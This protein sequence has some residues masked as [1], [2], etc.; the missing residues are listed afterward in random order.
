MK[1]RNS[2][3]KSICVLA[4]MCACLACSDNTATSQSYKFEGNEMTHVSK[5][6]EGEYIFHVLPGQI[7]R[8][9]EDGA[10]KKTVLTGA[11]GRVIADKS[12]FYF[13]REGENQSLR[14]ENCFGYADIEGNIIFEEEIERLFAEESDRELYLEVVNVFLENDTIYFVINTKYFTQRIYYFDQEHGRLQHFF[15]MTERREI[16]PDSIFFITEIKNGH[17]YY[18]KYSIDRKRHGVWKTTLDDPD[19]H[20]EELIEENEVLQSICYIGNDFLLGH[21]IE[22]NLIKIEYGRQGHKQ[23]IKNEDFVHS[24][25]AVQCDGEWIL[26]MRENDEK[27]EVYLMNIDGTDIMKVTDEWRGN[28]NQAL[29][30]YVYNFVDAE[31]DDD[32]KRVLMRYHLAL[33]LDTGEISTIAEW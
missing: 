11:Y 19:N 23:L 9:K 8:T 21:D 13:T 12:G 27:Y 15:E 10:D 24:P 4:I 6:D 32:H 1:I 29:G 26:F 22:E 28:Y 31:W 14:E 20:H 30:R 3:K 25:T 2:I 18:S 16:Y 7:L 17:I 33:N 5:Q